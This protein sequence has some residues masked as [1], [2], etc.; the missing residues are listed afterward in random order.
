M[1]KYVKLECSNRKGSLDSD[2]VDVLS[3]NECRLKVGLCL[4]STKGPE[5]PKYTCY[6]A[7]RRGWKWGPLRIVTWQSWPTR[8]GRRINV[9]LSQIIVETGSCALDFPDPECKAWLN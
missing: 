5:R 9:Q 3:V 2:S 6:F 8:M 7:C 1:S 4:Y